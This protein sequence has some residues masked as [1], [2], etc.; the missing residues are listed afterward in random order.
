MH[1][2]SINMIAA[3]NDVIFLSLKICIIFIIISSR[4]ILVA[5]TA[6]NYN[7]EN[8][9]N[10]KSN[11]QQQQQEKQ[12]QKQQQTQLSRTKDKQTSKAKQIIQVGE[13]LNFNFYIR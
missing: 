1:A 11:Q 9:C 6:N 12:Q 3:N 4:S 8:A 7:Y 10:L 2:S 13:K 5:D